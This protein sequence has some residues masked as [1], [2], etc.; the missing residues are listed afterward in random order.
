MHFQV[1]L[2]PGKWLKT[3]A[4]AEF[5]DVRVFLLAIHSNLH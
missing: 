1:H 2:R 5:L 4:E 3:K